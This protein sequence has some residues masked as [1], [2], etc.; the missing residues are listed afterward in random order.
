MSLIEFQ[1]SKKKHKKMPTYFFQVK[2]NTSCIHPFIHPSIHVVVGLSLL[3]PFPYC[4]SKS[5]A[6]TISDGYRCS[7]RG[8]LI[9]DHVRLFLFENSINF[10]QREFQCDFKFFFFLHASF[11][12]LLFLSFCL[13]RAFL[14][15]F[16]LLVS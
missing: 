11:M 10:D 1:H 4:I 12:F 6:F 5:I 3:Y 2:K 13:I 16:V 8:S 14:M 7:G 15:Q 9:I